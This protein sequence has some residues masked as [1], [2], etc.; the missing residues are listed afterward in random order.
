MH[1]LLA[2]T[3]THVVAFL[4]FYWV[5]KRFAWEPL[6]EA[7][8]HRREH[9]REQLESAKRARQ[10]AEKA[11]EEYQARVRQLE[12]E[13]TVRLQKAVA[14][15]RRLAEEIERKAREEASRILRTAREQAEAELLRVREALQRDTAELV[16]QA[17]EDLLR[18]VLDD[19]LHLRI[20]EV[21]AEKL[22]RQTEGKGS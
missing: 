10:E 20:V 19:R 11:R 6:L 4:L 2:E 15:G 17:T 21:A 16:V 3:L 9:I 12:V 7:L 18:D 22:E 13:E 1:S 5:L 14:E 8:D